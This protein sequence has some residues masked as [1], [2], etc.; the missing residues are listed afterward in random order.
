[1]ETT[2]INQENKKKKLL[3]DLTGIPAQRPAISPFKNNKTPNLYK[4][5]SNPLKPSK[6][7]FQSKGLPSD[8]TKSFKR[9]ELVMSSILEQALSQ[10]QL[11]RT[12]Q[13]QMLRRGPHIN[14]SS[15]AFQLKNKPAIKQIRSPQPIARPTYIKTRAN[16]G[17]PV[18]W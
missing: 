6:Y 12:R 4:I 1:M 5:T 15:L 16:L 7:V 10:L 14:K 2:L 8:M 13:Q 3:S 18:T 9:Q 17:K 11:Q